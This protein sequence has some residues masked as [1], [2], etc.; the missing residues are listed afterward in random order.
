MHHTDL[1][2]NSILRPGEP[3]GDF[4]QLAA[5]FSTLEDEQS[6]EHS[7]REWYDKQ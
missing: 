1:A 5:W 2:K 3:K 7:L 6:T 4:G